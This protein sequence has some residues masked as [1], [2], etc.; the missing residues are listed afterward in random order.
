MLLAIITWVIPGAVWWM[1]A[2]RQRWAALHGPGSRQR[3]VVSYCLDR[4]AG[5]VHRLRRLRDRFSRTRSDVVSG[6]IRANFRKR[7]PTDGPRIPTIRHGGDRVLRDPCRR[8]VPG[9]EHPA[10]AVALRYQE[11]QARATK[12]D[13]GCSPTN[14]TGAGLPPRRSTSR[15]T[16]SAPRRHT[17]RIAGSRGSRAACRGPGRHRAGRRSRARSR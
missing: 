3:N 8:R 16:P 13:S 15:S 12:R 9:D 14:G 10:T 17:G 4:R 2:E 1:R 7:T 5:H 11:P 6:P